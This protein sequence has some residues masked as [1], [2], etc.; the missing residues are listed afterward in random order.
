MPETYAEQA[1]IL[2]RR[3]FRDYDYSVSAYT[4]SRGKVNLIAKGA[5]RP[6]SKLAAHLEPLTLVEMMIIIGRTATV[7]GVVSRD[8]YVHCKAD[9]DKIL[10][11]SRAI[12]QAG[13]WLK[14]HEADEK[15][16]FLFHDFLDLLNK[17]RSEPSWYELMSTIFLYKILAQLGYGL[18]S[19]VCQRC[20]SNIVSE[21]IFSLRDHGFLC[22]NCVKGTKGTR[23]SKRLQA[24]IQQYSTETISVIADR[25]VLKKDI[26]SLTTVLALWVRYM[27]E[28]LRGQRKKDFVFLL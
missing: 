14:E 13:S 15:I 28:E 23:I 12:S 6:Q 24:V 10:S 20:G 25:P 22:S 26:E 18:E 2:H 16:F 11:A 4:R 21:A 3:P 17:R 9:I 27:D 19:D 1:I 5:L 7:G 8:C